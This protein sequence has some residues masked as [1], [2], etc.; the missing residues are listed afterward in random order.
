MGHARMIRLGVAAAV[1]L[2][3]PLLVPAQ[4][5]KDSAP[6]L[7]TRAEP[8]AGDFDMMLERRVVRVLVPYS[9]TLYFND[10]GKERGLTAELVRDFEEY[11]NKKYKKSLHRRPITVL[12][13]PTPREQLITHVVQ[14]LGDIAAGNLTVTDER[15]KLVDFI[16]P[17]DLRSVSEVVLTRKQDGPV[18]TVDDLA[19]RTVHVRASSSYHESLRLVNELLTRTGQAP[20]K[21]VTVPDVLEDEDLMEMVD[22][23]VIAAIVVDD[24]KAKMWAQILPNVIVN[25]GAAVRSGGQTGWAHR[26][27]SPLLRAELND[28]YYQYEKQRGTIPYRL[29]QYNKQVKRLQDPTGRNDWK[30]FRETVALFEKYGAQ[31]GFD[32]LMLAAQGFQESRLDQSVRSPVGAIGVMQLMPDTGAS[33]KVGDVTITEPNVHAGAKYMNTIMTDYFQDANFDELNRTLF[34]FASYNAGPNRISKLRKVAAERGLNPDVW[35]ENVEVVVSEKVGS[36]TTTY[37]RNIL[38]YYV[39]YKLTLEMQ[40][41]QEKAREAMSPAGG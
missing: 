23:G 7:Q 4:D 15:S 2:A 31:Y 37:V 27:N 33:M 10:K 3:I 12:I 32:P 26:K 1:L 40:R 19:G 38:K 21:I 14:G 16:A 5:G 30:R 41:E 22:A 29:G 39:S 28:F 8:H 6:T 25:A 18:A 17:D 35:F 11:L 24:W 20:V 34:A 9:R 13:I 36:E